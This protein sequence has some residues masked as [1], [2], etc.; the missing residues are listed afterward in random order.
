MIYFQL[1]YYLN[2]SASVYWIESRPRK[3]QKYN[4]SAYFKTLLQVN[5]ATAKK[6]QDQ[7]DGECRT[8]GGKYTGTAYHVHFRKKALLLKYRILKAI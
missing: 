6:K 2:S 5:I 8:S 7:L 4:I 3:S 1:S